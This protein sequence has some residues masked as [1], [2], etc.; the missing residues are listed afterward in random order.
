[1]TVIN[2]LGQKIPL[3]RANVNDLWDRIQRHHA[4]EDPRIWRDLAIFALREAAGWNL[5]Q[6]ALAL[7]LSRGHVCRCL[8]EMKTHLQKRFRLEPLSVEAW[9]VLNHP[10]SE[11]ACAASER[12]WDS[13][14]RHE[15]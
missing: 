11:L 10:D 7:G 3:P 1:M 4:Q 13:D 15:Q 6:I 2:E 5:E 12:D 14:P 8:K 9:D